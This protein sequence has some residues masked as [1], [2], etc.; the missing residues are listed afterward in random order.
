[1]QKI[2]VNSGNYLAVMVYIFI[3]SCMLVKCKTF[4]FQ[5]VNLAD[6]SCC[7]IP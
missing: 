7:N 3:A 5:D 2:M 1:M 4:T 6:Y